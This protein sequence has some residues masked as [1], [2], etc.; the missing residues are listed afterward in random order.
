MLKQSFRL[1]SLSAINLF[2][3][4]ELR[5]GKDPEKKH[6]SMVMAI[7]WAIVAVVLE[8]YLLISLIGLT[9][10]GAGEILPIY[11]F[12]LTS[13]M[14]LMFTMLKAGSVIFQMNTYETLVA[15][16]VP[17]GAIVV[18]RFMTMYTSNI[19]FAAAIMVPGMIVYGIS[20]GK[21]FGFVLMF[22]LGIVFAPLL[23]MTVAT[24]VSAVI[25]GLSSRMKHKSLVEAGLMI[26]LVL[27][28]MVS[29][30]GM[31]ESSFEPEAISALS[32]NIAGRIGKGYP[33]AGWFETAVKE[34]RFLPMAGVILV[35]VGIFALMIY[36]LQFF[37]GKICVA[38]NVFHTK[39][40]YE[41]V[42]GDSNSLLMSLVKREFRYYFSQ[43]TY[44]MNTAMGLI[45]MVVAAVAL[46]VVGPEK[47]EAQLPVKGIAMKAIPYIMALTACIAS[48]TSTSISLEG[49]TRWLTLSLPIPVK[50][51]YDSKLLMALLLDAPF[52][53]I[54]VAV[55]AIGLKATGFD[56]LWLIVL[57]ALYM[58]FSA[59]WG[60]T[61]NLLAPI[62]HWESEVY[63][64]KQSFSVLIAMVGGMVAT[65][66]PLMACVGIHILGQQGVIPATLP[67][68][69]IFNLVVV[70]IL[71]GVCAVLYHKNSQRKLQE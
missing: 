34:N 47:I 2:G 30:S 25:K 68:G 64:V 70:V 31:Q 13:A 1:W 56:L 48:P 59:V 17:R 71:L 60:Q 53:V 5:Y 6:H 49:K 45:M 11:C 69:N 63:V 39:N 66:L 65:L 44:M 57:P 38:L 42:K 16:P 12:T 35:S 28:I 50:T 29:T 26:A 36:V 58:V 67:L 61:A 19:L 14:V 18:S 54:S 9:M 46:V 10:I 33:L 62:F 3:I 4:N 27:I 41:Q 51:Q 8:V 22:L 24:A 43:S 20:T 7:V 40:N 32:A 52:Y 15:L 21:G 23:P 55:A 37:F